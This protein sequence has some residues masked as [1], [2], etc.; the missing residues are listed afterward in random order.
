MDV[1]SR[2]SRCVLLF[3]PDTWDVVVEVVPDRR[4]GTEKF[5]IVSFKS[6]CVTIAV[7]SAWVTLTLL[8]LLPKEE[9]TADGEWRGQRGP[10]EREKRDV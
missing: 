5:P 10:E 4:W 9:A 2:R 6:Q 8:R 1:L 7:P 3:P